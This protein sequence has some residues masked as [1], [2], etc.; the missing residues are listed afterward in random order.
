MQQLFHYVGRKKNA[1]IRRCECRKRIMTATFFELKFHL[2]KI[3][4]NLIEMKAAHW[5]ILKAC[6]LQN[7]PKNANLQQSGNENWNLSDSNWISANRFG[8]IRRK[9]QNNQKNKLFI[10]FERINNRHLKM[11]TLL[12]CL[13]FMP[14][15]K[16]PT[17]RWCFES[18][19][20]R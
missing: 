10:H 2:F 5:D 1:R 13:N 18:T 16:H 11:P 15:Q 8:V 17:V 19:F 14:K 20:C 6:E 9:K 4:W 3:V 12:F 7:E